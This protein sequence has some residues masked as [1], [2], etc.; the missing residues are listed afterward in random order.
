MKNTCDLFQQVQGIKLQ[1]NESIASFDVSVL[2][3]SVPIDP[4]ITIIRRKVEL[5]QEL[6]LRKTM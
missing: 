4:A 1:P 6:P 2:F 3:T 5:D